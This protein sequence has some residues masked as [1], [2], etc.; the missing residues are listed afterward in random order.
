M[1]KRLV[2]SLLLALPVVVHAQPAEPEAPPPDPTTSQPP[3]PPPPEPAPVEQPPPAPPPVADCKSRRREQVLRANTISDTQE[4]G[5]YLSSIPECPSADPIAVDA[6]AQ[7]PGYHANGIAFGVQFEIAPTP[8][9]SGGGATFVGLPSTHF[10]IGYQGSAIGVGLTLD[11]ERFSQGP[12]MASA[13]GA[14]QTATTLL[15][16]PAIRIALAHSE[17]GKTELL[18]VGSV[19]YRIFD[20]TGG[21]QLDHRVAARLGPSIQHWLSPSFAIAATT[22]VRVDSIKP[23]GDN[24]SSLVAAS[25][26]YAIDLTGVF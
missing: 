8:M 19:A 17:S 1:M 23:N 6:D 10:N 3:V 26:A 20:V 24:S 4:R 9:A 21:G 2:A 18:T 14:D 15:L 5:R 11:L 25:L 12:A 13:P 16:G 7:A 22:A